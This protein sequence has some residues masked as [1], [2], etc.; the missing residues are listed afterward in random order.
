MK[1]FVSG[2]IVG[3]LLFG[4]ASVFAESVSLIGK[5]VSGVYTIEKNGKKVAEAVIINGSAYAPVRAVAE[6]TGA[7]LKV[8]GKKIIMSETNQG[9]SATATSE[10][11]SVADLQV[12]REKVSAVIEQKKAN[13][14]DLETNVIPLYEAQVKDLSTN[15]A[16]AQQVQ[17]TVDS[18]KSILEQRK[19][20]LSTLQQQLTDLDAK[21]AA[22]LK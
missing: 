4:G 8:E 14:T 21:I 9:S 5:K 7:G 3:A 12:E 18:Y 19:T 20:E 16:L 15:S 6:A 10:Q 22:L 17:G 11:K 13:I 1:K 2:V